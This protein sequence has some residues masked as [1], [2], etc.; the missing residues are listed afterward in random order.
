NRHHYAAATTGPPPPAR[1]GSIIRASRSAPG[2][3]WGCDLLPSNSARPALTIEAWGSV[4]GRI[5]DAAPVRRLT[6]QPRNRAARVGHHEPLGDAAVSVGLGQP[7][8]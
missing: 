8:L 5:Y 6:Q 3:L 4:R 2:R 7:E 1:P